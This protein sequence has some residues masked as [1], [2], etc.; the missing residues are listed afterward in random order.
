MEPLRRQKMKHA[1]TFVLLCVFISANVQA[2]LPQ[3]RGPHVKSIAIHPK[4]PT[5]I[6]AISD[7][8][9]FQ[10]INGGKK[11]TPVTRKYVIGPINALAFDQSNPDKFYLA[12]GA[13]IFL[14]H[15]GGQTWKRLETEGLPDGEVADLVVDPA[16]GKHWL[17][18]IEGNIYSSEDSGN[19]WELAST[20]EGVNSLVFHPHQKGVAYAGASQGMLRSTDSG[21]TWVIY[22]DSIAADRKY[23]PFYGPLVANDKKGTLYTKGDTPRKSSDGGLSWQIL[24]PHCENLAISPSSSKLLYV[25]CTTEDGLEP[26]ATIL[27]SIDGGETWQDVSKGLPGSWMPESIYINP[28]NPKNVF[29]GWVGGGIY[30]TVDGGRHWFE[31][32]GGL[33]Y[34]N[35]IQFRYRVYFQESPLV[36]HV[37][38]GDLEG[39]KEALKSGES[40]DEASIGAGS[41]LLWAAKLK[42]LEIARLLIER[43]VDIQHSNKEGDSALHFAAENTDIEMARLLV[44]HGADVNL[45]AVSEHRTPFLISLGYYK[46]TSENR[47]LVELFIKNG[48]NLNEA[49]LWPIALSSGSVELLELLYK[50]GAPLDGHMPFRTDLVVDAARTNNADLVRFFLDKGLDPNPHAPRYE[51]A[52]KGSLTGASSD[53]RLAVIKLLLAHGARPDA[54]KGKYRDETSTALMLAADNDDGRITTALLDAGANPES[55][56]KDG[57]SAMEH[58]INYGKLDVVAALISGGAKPDSID[59]KGNTALHYAAALTYYDR[60][61]NYLSQEADRKAQIIKALLNA[62]WSKDKKN[63]DGKIPIDLVPAGEKFESSRILLR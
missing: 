43:G 26:H 6:F 33:L 17:C 14:T 10:S 39:V 8:G 1:R 49:E 61:M 48:A 57:K 32:S 51:S 63:A 42:R 18:I 50:K 58:A 5:R 53:S 41:P 19:K 24:K 30:Q 56:D 13:G 23:A 40:A 36:Q 35:N 31:S 27:R 15:D 9:L 29:M 47:D 60:T 28:A 59:P 22:G 38:D 52:I 46:N 37:M 21:K 16:N 2:S 54:M 34:K 62:G 55:R 11:W 44:G 3:E 20:G 25:S 45:R 12:T 7:T 4:R